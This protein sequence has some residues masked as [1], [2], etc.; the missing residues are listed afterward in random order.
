MDGVP[1]ATINKVLNN[2]LGPNDPPFSGLSQTVT[3]IKPLLLLHDCIFLVFLLMW[4]SSAMLIP[5]WGVWSWLS[6]LFPNPPPKQFVRPDCCPACNYPTLNLPSNIC[7]ECGTA[8]PSP[9]EP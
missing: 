2:S 8:L 9:R 7:P 3:R 1:I 5:W 6:S 4:L